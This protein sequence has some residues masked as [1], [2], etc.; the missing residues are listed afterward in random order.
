MDDATTIAENRHSQSDSLDLANQ[1]ANADG[2]I[3]HV[4]VLQ[5]HYETIEVIFDKV[6]CSESDR[7]TDD[8]NTT[9]QY[10]DVCPQFLKDHQESGDKD[11]NGGSVLKNTNECFCSILSFRFRATACTFGYELDGT[12]S[13]Q[14]SE[15]IQ[16]EHSHHNEKQSW[17]MNHDPLE[18]VSYRVGIL[19][20]FDKFLGFL[21]FS[22]FACR[23]VERDDV[24]RLKV[25]QFCAM[26]AQAFVDLRYVGTRL[27]QSLIRVGDC[28][29]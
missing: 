27:D 25:T 18:N 15:P 6:L 7:Q 3:E 20:A 13:K 4:L 26:V 19:Q 29:F 2:I 14:R 24:L 21:C 23:F 16:D 10:G 12:V 28:L 1:S 22:T 5:Q 8:S 17:S 9:H 11:A